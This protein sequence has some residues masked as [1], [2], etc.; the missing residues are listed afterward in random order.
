MRQDSI[1]GGFSLARGFVV[2]TMPAIHSVLFY[3]EPAVK[4]GVLGL[5]LGFLAE[6]AGAP[7]FMLL[8]GV[9][10]AYSRPKSLIDIGKRGVLLILL[11]YLLNTLKFIIPGLM[12]WLPESFITDNGLSNDHFLFQLLG[13][14]DIL[15]F[16]GL[17][18]I[19]CFLIKRFIVLLTF[20]ILLV[21]LLLSFTPIVWS[22]SENV[23]YWGQFLYGEPPLVYFPM[24]PWLVYPL[25]GL[26][27]GQVIK[28]MTTKRVALILVITAVICISFGGLIYK[29]E[30]PEWNQN[31]Y[32]LGIGGTLAHIGFVFLWLLLFV[33]LNWLIRN[34][35]LFTFLR[36]LSKNVTV[37]YIIQWVV[38]CWFLPLFG[39]NSLS[40]YPSLF[41]ILFVTTLSFILSR[42]F[43]YYFQTSKK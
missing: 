22:L 4:E 21:L 43:L 2:L 37:V 8:M 36:W 20:Q 13:L 5:I 16:A 41:A 33:L 40:G 39:Y 34:N 15:Q 3:S 17:A 28:E 31:F 38:V 14:I 42:L 9:F 1:K 24:F 29:V 18:Y 6:T 11:G 32:R 26:I 35:L 27:L 7:V 12:G 19:I 23:T 25:S 30:P 10:V